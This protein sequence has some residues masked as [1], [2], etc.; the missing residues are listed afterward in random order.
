L[1]G[2]G[3]REQDTL[4]SSHWQRHQFVAVELH[5]HPVLAWAC[6]WGGCGRQDQWDAHLVVVDKVGRR[7]LFEAI[8]D[9]TPGR[10]GW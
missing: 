9:A 7:Q 1:R 6:D 2:N 8:R 5:G 10:L 4:D 3:T